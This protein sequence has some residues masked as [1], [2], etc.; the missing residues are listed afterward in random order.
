MTPFVVRNP[1]K[2]YKALAAGVRMLALDMDGTA[3][4]RMKKLTPR[5]EKAIRDALDAGIVT[6]VVTG[7]PMTGAPKEVLAI[8]GIRYVI[9]SNGAITYDLETNEYLRTAC[10]V[11]EVA[12]EIAKLPMEHELIHSVFLDGVGYCEPLYYNKQMDFYRGSPLEQYFFDSRKSTDDIHGTIDASVAGAENIW[13]VTKTPEQQQELNTY[14]REHWD[15]HTVLMGKT[16][17]EIGHPN[18]EKGKAVKEL[19]QML[20]IEPGQIV[21]FGDNGNDVGMFQIAGISVAMGN[22]PEHIREQADLTAD[23]NEEEGVAK[24]IEWILDARKAQ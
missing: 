14:V 18:A 21:S 7:R 2:D 24:V 9:T 12:K 17:V 6:V 3:L 13:F 4:T 22:A 19:A 16:D 20:G 8:P 10:L 1:D 5:T 23:T 11:P 15:V